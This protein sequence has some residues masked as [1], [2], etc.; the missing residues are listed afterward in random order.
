MAPNSFLSPFY[1][2]RL[3]ILSLA[4]IGFN[5]SAQHDDHGHCG[6]D[7]YLE[8]QLANPEIYNQY[9]GP[10]AEGQSEVE[11][12][13]NGTVLQIPVV[14]HVIYATQ[15]DNISKAQILDALRIL[16]EDFRRTN[17]DTSSTRALFRPVAVDTE[18]EFVL[19]KKDRNGNCIDGITRNQDN[20]SLYGNDGSKR[21]ATDFPRSRYLNIWVVRNVRT[22]DP[23]NPSN[24]LGYATFPGNTSSSDGIIVRH[25]ELGTIGTAANSLYSS[26]G[27]TLTHEVGHYLGL[28][29]TFFPGEDPNKSGCTGATV[30]NNWPF[31]DVP[32][33][34][35]A[36]KG[37][38]CDDTPPVVA[39]NFGCSPSTNTCNSD[40]PDLVD[41]IENYMDYTSCQNMFSADQKARMRHTLSGLRGTLVSGTNASFTGLVNPPVCTPEAFL[42]ADREIICDGETIQFSDISEEG[43]PTSWTW[44]FPGGNPASSTSQNPSVT[45]ANPGTYDV[46][47]TVSNS[48]GTDT[49]T[50]SSYITV[51]NNSTPVFQTTWVESFENGQLPN[52]VTAVDGGDGNTFKHF[53]NA[54][55][56]QSSSLVLEDASLSYGE[57]DE[58]IS[59]AIET[60]GASSLNLFFDYAFAA[61]NANNTDQLE[62]FVSRDCGQSWIR[63]RFYNSGR[64]QSAPMT[65]ANFV[66]TA[67][68]WKTE[69]ISF[70]AYIG[71]DPILIKFAFENGGGNNFYIDNIRFGQ[72]TDVSLN[73]YQAA[74]LKV[75]P[76]PSQGRV[77]LKLSDL[78][79]RSLSLQVLDLSGKMVHQEALNIQG[80]NLEKDLD[81]NLAPGV[82]LME[83]R[84]QE[85]RLSEKL[86]IE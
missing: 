83:I 62:V 78:Q 66:P 37:D 51:K 1:M 28:F 14:F 34:S 25:D 18:I 30:G 5:L 84:G 8:E 12:V 24:V 29:H 20:T 52:L 6:F 77:H 33:G 74:D 19:A 11:T 60:S 38:F 82:Y 56:H 67:S 43:V 75:Y 31:T 59:P 76:N 9:F 47:L 58:L 32:G 68:Q 50:Y 80:S 7:Q 61:K 86:I 46:T 85:T 44:S 57:I 22:S 4:F 69:T 21:Y 49:K 45:Y 64:L 55:S 23:A 3:F 42:E 35:N 17:A 72:G 48:A 41:Q 81:L 39:S 53:A 70:D 26:N 54:G 13:A 15:R 40:S 2:K 65:T 73:E 27:R 10:K 16:N 79:D 63:R 71:P 36:D